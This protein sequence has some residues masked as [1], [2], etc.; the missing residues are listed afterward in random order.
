MEQNVFPDRAP[1]LQSHE[2]YSSYN[3]PQNGVA[4]QN[5]RGGEEKGKGKGWRLRYIRQECFYASFLQTDQRCTGQHGT[6]TM[7]AT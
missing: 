7:H 3:D 1:T 6:L 5:E 4:T 2:D